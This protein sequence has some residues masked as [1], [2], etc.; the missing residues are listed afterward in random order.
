MEKLVA[1][2]CGPALAGIKPANIVAC[3]KTKIKDIHSEVERL[4]SQLN[5]KDIYFR[6]LYEH[7][8]RTLL[9]VYRSRVLKKYLAREEIAD[10]LY[11]YGYPYEVTIDR[12]INHLATRLK[13]DEFPHEIG[14][15]LGYPLHDILG[16]IN[17]KNEGCLLVGEWK[18]YKNADEARQLF[19]RFLACRKAIIRRLAMGQTLAQV[20]CAVR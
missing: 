11:S 10:F 7:K 1:Y 9:I 20:F 2:Y 18:V 4:N 17:H 3:D 8:R 16:F 5:C 14:A 19:E 13:E 15:F 12:Y 6:V